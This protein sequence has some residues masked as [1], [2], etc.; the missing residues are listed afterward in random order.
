MC[1]SAVNPKTCTNYI[2]CSNH[3]HWAFLSGSFLTAVCKYFTYFNSF[4]GLGRNIFVIFAY[5]LLKFSSVLLLYCSPV[6]EI[7]S[8]L[9]VFFVTSFKEV[10]T[11]LVNLGMEIEFTLWILLA[12]NFLG[13][14]WKASALEI[15]D[16]IWQHSWGLNV[17]HANMHYYHQLHIKSCTLLTTCLWKLKVAGEY[18]PAFAC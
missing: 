12:V 16:P 7:G 5:F 15:I 8:F 3:L 10:K 18:F 9:W 1:M 6:W 14:F 17:R 11:V 13:G 4:Y 2:T